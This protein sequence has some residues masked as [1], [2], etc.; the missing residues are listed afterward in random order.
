M[1][2]VWRV[3]EACEIPA[4]DASESNS[5]FGVTPCCSHAS[6]SRSWLDWHDIR[7]RECVL[8]RGRYLHTPASEEWL[9]WTSA[10]QAGECCGGKSAVTSPAPNK[11]LAPR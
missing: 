3:C 6:E 10:K 2:A 8:D 4:Q 7:P 1:C 5:E 11:Q 9:R